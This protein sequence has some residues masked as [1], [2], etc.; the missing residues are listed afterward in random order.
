MLQ[1]AP[2][3]LQH[4]ST[5]VRAA[6][7]DFI[8]AAAYFLTP[9]DVYAHLLPLVM[10]AVTSEPAALTSQAAIVQQLPQQLQQAALER[11]GLGSNS[12]P[13]KAPGSRQGPGSYTASDVSASSAS[14]L[15]RA[16]AS[17][18]A[19]I[20]A[21]AAMMLTFRALICCSLEMACPFLAASSSA[22]CR[23]LLISA[24]NAAVTS[25]HGMQLYTMPN[26]H[27]LIVS[28]PLES[29]GHVHWL[30]LFFVE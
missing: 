24:S 13:S 28:I 15:K 10:P 5:S 30:R 11:T 23:L 8:A 7:V 3:L 27:M 18:L 19:G 9:A 17:P 21:I 22:G 20:P 29:V 6:A 12:S 25:V 2:A 26:F 16:G 4:P 1:V 14:S